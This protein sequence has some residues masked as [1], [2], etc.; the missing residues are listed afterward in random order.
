MVGGDGVDLIDDDL[1]E[2]L[3]HL[4]V[5][6]LVVGPRH[7]VVVA[8]AVEQVV[9]RLETHQGTEFLLEDSLD[10][11]SPEGADTVL[12]TGRGV[13]AQLQPRVLIRV[14]SRRAA[15]AGSL[16]EGLDPP[17]IVLGDPVL[18]RL[19]RTPQ[20]VGDVLGG[21]PLFGEGDGLNTAP[22]SLPGDGLSEVVKL[23]RGMMIG[24][25]H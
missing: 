17:A 20:G 23:F 8:E 3:L 11:E 14:Q 2:E 10:V 1:L 19:E 22:E 18:D 13:Q 6:V 24:D 25:E 9:D 16:V 7:E 21:P 15:A 4:R 12:G 5:G